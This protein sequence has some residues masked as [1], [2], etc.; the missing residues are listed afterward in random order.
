MFLTSVRTFNHR[1]EKSNKDH[2]L[3]LGNMLIIQPRVLNMPRLILYIFTHCVFTR[4]CFK[5]FLTTVTIPIMYC[6]V[7][8]RVRSDTVKSAVMSQMNQMPTSRPLNIHHHI[9]KLH[10]RT[11]TFVEIFLPK[12][13]VHSSFPKEVA[14]LHPTDL[15]K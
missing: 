6:K 1:V 11:C 4:A 14:A 13:C 7:Q 5:V 3:I 9:I 15:N 12:L 2:H 8:H 10:V